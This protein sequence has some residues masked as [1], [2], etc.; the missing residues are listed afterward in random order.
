M[1]Q[2][3]EA[4][5]IGEPEVRRLLVQAFGV[6]IE[7]DADEAEATLASP[8]REIRD[9]AAH[10]RKVSEPPSVLRLRHRRPAA[11]TRSIKG[12]DLVL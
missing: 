5:R 7:I 6:R 9:A 12:P 10:I 8:W 11:G 4:Y 3:A 1:H 2:A